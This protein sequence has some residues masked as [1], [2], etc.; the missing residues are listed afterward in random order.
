MFNRL[1]RHFFCFLLLVLKMMEVRANQRD[2]ARL[3]ETLRELLRNVIGNSKDI[4]NGL[5][6][7]LNDE[8]P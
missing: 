7:I 5:V 3:T 4:C 1:N 6:D 8:P 2:E